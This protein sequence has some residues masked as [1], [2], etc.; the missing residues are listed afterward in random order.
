[1]LMCVR[2]SRTTRDQARAA[3]AAIE[4]LPERPAGLVVTGV[5]SGDEADYGYY[6]ADADRS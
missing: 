1:V 4:H 5:R 2:A 6:Y 3:K